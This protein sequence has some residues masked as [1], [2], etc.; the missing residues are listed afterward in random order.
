MVAQGRTWN[1]PL[2]FE[3]EN[4]QIT[5]PHDMASEHLSSAHCCADGYGVNAQRARWKD[6][7]K[8]NGVKLKLKLAGAA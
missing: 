2:S 4:V 3:W 5:R 8:C 1:F 6:R 7:Q